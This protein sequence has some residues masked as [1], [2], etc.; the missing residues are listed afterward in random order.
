MKMMSV[1]VKKNHRSQKDSTSIS[2]VRYR[3]IRIIALF[4]GTQ[5]DYEVAEI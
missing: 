3:K 2:N 5:R 1:Y 4:L